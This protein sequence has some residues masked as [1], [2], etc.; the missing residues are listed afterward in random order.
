MW[1]APPES[2][3]VQGASARAAAAGRVCHTQRQPILRRQPQGRD[4]GIEGSRDR[5]IEGSRDRGIY[6][7]GSEATGEVWGIFLAQ[8]IGPRPARRQKKLA[9]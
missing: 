2:Q 5:G 4:R 6:L 7:T 9:S 8:P 1:A 3:P